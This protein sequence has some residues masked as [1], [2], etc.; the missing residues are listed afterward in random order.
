M[1]IKLQPKRDE[2]GTYIAFKSGEKI[3]IDYV[4]FDLSKVVEGSTL[5]PSAISS[6][7]F[8]G[9]VERIDGDLKVQLFVSNPINYSQEQASPLPIVNP[10]D[11]QL[12]F[13]LPLPYE[14]GSYDPVPEF[15]ESVPLKNGIID[16]SQLITKEMKEAEQVAIA[17][18]AA[19]ISEDQWRTHEME[20][21][22]DQLI[23]IEDEDPDAL[24]GTTQEWRAYRTEVRSWKEGG[25]ENFPNAEHRPTR[26]E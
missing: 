22:A 9:V 25:N 15:D 12:T 11:G 3:I 26:P 13:P 21:I 10:E 5:P 16:W 14:D 4:V 1:F 6:N 2:N 17:R 23:A 20:F 8:A 18:V 19:V 7:R 24:P